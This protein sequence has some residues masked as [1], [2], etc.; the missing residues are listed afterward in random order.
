MAF[1]DTK[2][3]INKLNPSRILEIF[4]E[5]FGD[6]NNFTF[7]IV[8]DVDK[9]KLEKLI[10]TYI[11][12]LP[13]VERNETYIDRSINLVK[14]KQKFIRY[15]NNENISHVV[16][17]YKSNT[18]HNIKNN[19]TLNLLNNII[20]IKLRKKIR[21]DK[22]GSYHVKVSATLSKVIKNNSTV[23]ISF[24]CDPK[25]AKVLINEVYSIILDLKNEP[26]TSAEL[27]TAK[28]ILSMRVES[29]MK[30][31][32]FWLMA[33]EESNRRNIPLKKVFELPKIIEELTS[34]DIKSF[35]NKM[36]SENILQQELHP[37]SLL[38]K[39]N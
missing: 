37:K 31:N 36:F 4:K 16:L 11:G 13:S 33:M 21:E 32:G 27:S 35:A 17:S 12:N 26:I 19:I 23:N 25:K 24:S 34:A 3:S 5:R 29:A 1:Y 22:S 15:Y 18:P 2:K 14:G 20:D 6:L 7:F 9:L 39:G 30:Q 28:K 8:G 10:T 38:T